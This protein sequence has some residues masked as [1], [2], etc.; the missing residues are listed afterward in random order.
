M[1]CGVNWDESGIVDE[2][3]TRCQVPASILWEVDLDGKYEK[4]AVHAG[5][6]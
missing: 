1:N 4:A 2:L 3:E 6:H 5:G